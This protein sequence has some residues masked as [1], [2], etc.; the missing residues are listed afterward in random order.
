MEKMKDSGVKWIGKVPKEWDVKKIKYEY[1]IQTGF[2][3]DTSNDEYYTDEGGGTWISI[4]DMSNA[5]NKE[6][7]NS[8]IQIS[9][10]YVDEKH[11]SITKKGSLLKGFLFF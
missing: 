10:K 8:S 6:I 9:K 1:E 2:T 5:R 11:P 7:R 3:P 4:A